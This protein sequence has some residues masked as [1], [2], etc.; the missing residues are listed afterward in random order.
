KRKRHHDQDEEGSEHRPEDRDPEEDPEDEGRARRFGGRGE[1]RRQ[2]VAP[3]P[4]REGRGRE[5]GEGAGGEGAGGEG[6]A[7]EGDVRGGAE[8]AKGGASRKDRR[9]A[10]ALLRRAGEDPGA[11]RRGARREGLEGDGPRAEADAPPRQPREDEGD[12]D[13]DGRLAEDR[14]GV[15]ARRG[16]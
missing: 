13:R 8:A 11:A 9:G 15:R 6:R 4:P 5:G 3:L 7:Q 1:D 12:P 10:A 2:E 16:E 14:L